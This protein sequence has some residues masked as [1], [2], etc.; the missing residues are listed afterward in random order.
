[1]FACDRQSVR[2]AIARGLYGAWRP[3]DAERQRLEQIFPTGVCD[4]RK[5]DQGRP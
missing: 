3:N 5:P 2:A 4:Y 1:M